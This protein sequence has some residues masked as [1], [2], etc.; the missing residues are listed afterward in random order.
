M[1]YGANS[2]KAVQSLHGISP[3]FVQCGVYSSVEFGVKEIDF[4]IN[5][6]PF[7]SYLFPFA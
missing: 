5:P 4:V 3:A 2:G 6:L 1:E 7:T